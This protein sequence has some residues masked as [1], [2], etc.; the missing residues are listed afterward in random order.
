MLD[1]LWMFQKTPSSGDFYCL[2][3]IV[4]QEQT[5]GRF[6][7]LDGQQRLTTLY[8]IVSFLEANRMDEG[9]NQPLFTLN[10]ETRDNCKIFLK[11]KHFKVGTNDRNIDFY[12]ITQAYE[13]IKDWFADPAH[14]GAKSKLVPILL[15]DTE[16]GNRNVRFIWYEVEPETNPIEIFIRLNVGKIPLTDAELTKALL[17]Q[18]DKYG[19]EELPFIQ[20]ALFELASEWDQI[21]YTMQQDSYWYFLNGQANSR[22]T[23]IEFIF[24][25]VASRIQAEHHYFTA[26]PLKHATFLTLSAHMQALLDGSTISPAVSRIDAVKE[27]WSRVTAYFEYFRDWF[28]DRTL[29][30]YIGFLFATSNRHTIDGLIKKSAELTK[31]NFVEFLK[32]EIGLLVDIRKKRRDSEGNASIVAL[33]DLNYE[34]IEHGDDKEEIRRI[35][36]LHNV[37]ATLISDKEKARFPFNLYKDTPRNGR[38]SL[39]H[40]HARNSASINKRENQN[41]WLRDHI[42]SIGSQLTTNS[43][44]L[45]DRMQAML[46]ADQ[47]VGAD[48][49]AVVEEV[50]VVANTLSG[51]DAQNVHAISNLCL[52]DASTNSQLNNSVFDVKREII[53]DRELQGSYIPICTR[54]VFLKAYTKYPATNAYWTEHD[55]AGYLQSIRAT[56]DEYTSAII[57]N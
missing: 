30:H 22:P 16:L 14:K 41:A 34:D 54:N 21:E 40:I 39:E 29:F 43:Q 52:I 9:Y 45:V 55:R 27:I 24:D 2:Q 15:D 28:H 33:E 42:R 25:L 10:Y 46:D 50:Y 37:H 19:A 17:L 32:R 5:D 51:V 38:W 13:V 49:D 11:E 3:P 31:R 48:F 44:E 1:D 12:H 57:H 35:L 53:K 20:H 4:L 7:V 26:K 18:E 23:Y 8:L 36:F 6:H 56:Y 47:I